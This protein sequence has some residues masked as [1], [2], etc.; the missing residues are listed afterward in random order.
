MQS[1]IKA[2]VILAKCVRCINFNI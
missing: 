2:Y 1:N